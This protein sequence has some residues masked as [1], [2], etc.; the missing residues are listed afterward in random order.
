MKGKMLKK[1]AK[2]KEETRQR[3]GPE[4]WPAPPMRFFTTTLT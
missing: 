1:K 4:V 2:S 3:T